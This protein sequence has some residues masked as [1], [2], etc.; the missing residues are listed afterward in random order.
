[1]TGDLPLPTD[2]ARRLAELI[3][4]AAAFKLIERHGGT[5]VFVPRQPSERIIALIGDAAAAQLCA[6]YGGDN[7]KV[8]LARAWRVLVYRARG[9]TYPAI[10]RAVGCSEDAVWRVLSRHE[11]TAKQFDLFG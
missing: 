10:A 11:R 8:P 6:A 5:R 4:A 3:G 9:L 7:I 2:E 1:M